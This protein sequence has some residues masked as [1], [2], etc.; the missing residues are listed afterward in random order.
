MATRPPLHEGYVG[1][2]DAVVVDDRLTIGKLLA[3]SARKNVKRLTDR[4]TV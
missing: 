3:N 2:D 1:Q 4:T